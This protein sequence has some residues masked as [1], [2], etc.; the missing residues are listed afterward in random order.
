M[1]ALLAGAAAIDAVGAAGKRSRPLSRPA[2]G[3]ASERSEKAKQLPRAQRCSTR[4]SSS[5]APARR[6]SNPW[7][8]PAMSTRSS[9]TGAWRR[10][11]A[12]CFFGVPGVAM[13]SDAKR[14]SSSVNI[15][16][17]QD[18]GRV[19]VIVDGARQ[20]FQRSG[21]GTQS[22]FWIDPELLQQVDVIRGPVANTYG[23]GAIGGVVFFDTKDAEDFLQ[24]GRDLGRF[25]DRTLRDQRQRLDHQRHRR[26]PLQR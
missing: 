26:L 11:P 9:S 8:R 13:Q 4:S 7:P 23:S 22:T 6:R 16:G 18:F 1:A 19:A 2:T 10:R 14:T 24:A 3:R 15:R 5:A 25:G 21:H 17:L 12:T 20:N